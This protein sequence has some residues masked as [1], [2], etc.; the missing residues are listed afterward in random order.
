VEIFSGHSFDMQRWTSAVMSLSAAALLAIGQTP[1]E[2]CRVEGTVLNAITGQPV[3]KAHIFLTPSGAR[4]LIAMTDSQGKYAFTDVAPGD[5]RL[6]AQREGYMEQHYGAKKYGP[7]PKEEQLELAAGS[8]KSAVDFRMTPLGSIMGF[9]RDEDGDPIRQVNVSILAYGYSQSAKGLQAV[10]A[11]QTD[12][13]GEYRLFDLQPGTYYLRAKPLSAQSPGAGLLTEAYATVYYPNS[14]QQAGA[15]VIELT[16]GQELRGTDFVLHPIAV[17]SIRGH[18]TRPMEA[19]RCWTSLET[20]DELQ[21]SFDDSVES[22]FVEMISAALDGV[23]DDVQFGSGPQVGKD[24]KFEFRNVPLGSHS[25]RGSCMVGKQRYSARISV[26]L[27]ASGLDNVELRPVG[28][29]TVTGQLR[30]EGESKSKLTDVRVSLLPPGGESIFFDGNGEPANGGAGKI[31]DDGTFSFRNLGPDTYRIQLTPPNDL[32]VKSITV[33]ARDVR[34]SGVDLSAGA[35]SVAVQ[36]VLSANGGTIEGTVE[37]GAGAAITL[38]PSDPQAPRSHAK[39]AIA[40][41]DGHYAFP[42]VAP[43]KYKLFAWEM[44]DTNAAMYDPDFRKPFESKAQT[45]EVEEKQKA[46]VQ[47]QLIPSMEK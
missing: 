27:D 45:V 15:S 2:K 40:G 6:M 35:M 34:E 12:A 37:N 1:D 18:V 39:M 23:P 5:Y 47:L 24:G 31:A 9:V 22:G 8:V 21:P 26:Q 13:L 32:Y 4:P 46:T 43:G 29:S 28:P 11:T 25:L 44:V 42:V 14:L 41:P 36:V 30:L 38:V 33:E 17:S 19:T 20:A 16:A 3:R 10:G 7:D